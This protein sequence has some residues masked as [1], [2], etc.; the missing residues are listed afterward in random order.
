MPEYRIIDTNVPL[1]AA[2]INENVT[3][4][5]KQHCVR[6]VNLVRNRAICIVIDRDGEVL[7]EYA[8]KV[9]QKRSSLLDLAGLFLIYVRSNSG[10]KERVHQIHLRKVNGEYADWPQDQTL[11]GFDPSDKKWVALALAFRQQ[12]GQDAP[13]A[14]AIERGWD[15]YG[16]ALNQHGVVLEHLCAES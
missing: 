5:C 4:L 11:T 8:N 9:H 12:T 16:E 13:V 15:K 3:L 6:V 7:R 14:Y 2:G 10:Y 1:T